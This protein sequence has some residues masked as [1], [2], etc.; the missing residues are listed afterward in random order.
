M[1]GIIVS[2]TSDDI[3]VEIMSP[4]GATSV[5]EY[6]Y[7]FLPLISSRL[8]AHDREYVRQRHITL[9]APQDAYHCG[10]FCIQPI[11]HRPSPRPQTDQQSNSSTQ[12]WSA[13]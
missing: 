6:D 4:T 1:H 8:E 2:E 7:F 5:L 10:A 11:G 3:F 13:V 9:I 12:P